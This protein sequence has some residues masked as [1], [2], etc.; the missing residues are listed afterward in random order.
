MFAASFDARSDR[1]VV[2]HVESDRVA[3]SCR[4][5]PPREALRVGGNPAAKSFDLALLIVLRERLVEIDQP[6][7][8]PRYPADQV[9]TALLGAITRYL[10]EHRF[11]HVLA[12]PEVSTLDGGHVAASLHRQAWVRSMS[13]DDYRVFPRRRLPIESLS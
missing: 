5:I 12:T 11:D 10:I 9:A 6:C 4:V 13:P 2:R 1:L 3:G 7:I 8:D